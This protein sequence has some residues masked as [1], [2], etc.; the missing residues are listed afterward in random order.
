VTGKFEL[1]LGLLISFSL[2]NYGDRL[3]FIHKILIGIGL[4]ILY[5]II[6]RIEV[7]IILG[8]PDMQVTRVL[9]V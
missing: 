1:G 7:Q 5:I 2:S 8:A 3:L 9:D 4:G 6:S